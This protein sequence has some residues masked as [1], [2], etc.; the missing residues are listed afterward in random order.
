[1]LAKKKS[2]GTKFVRYRNRDFFPV[3]NFSDTGTDTTK[4]NEKF[5]VPVRHTLPPSPLH[6]RSVPEKLTEKS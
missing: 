1:M 5:P 2:S 4:K 3:P 6:G